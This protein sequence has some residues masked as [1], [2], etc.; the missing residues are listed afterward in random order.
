MDWNQAKQQTK[1]I[2]AGNG[3]QLQ[4]LQ[5]VVSGSDRYSTGSTTTY[6]YGDLTV[7]WITG[8]FKGIVSPIKEDDI[9]IEVG[10]Y[11]DDYL[12]VFIDPDQ[13][14]EYW[15]QL[16]IPSGS[17]NRYIILPIESWSPAGITVAKML[18]VRRLMPKSGSV[19]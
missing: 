1:A 11:E 17:D 12:K 13:S 7:F 2:I 10:F 8:S 6:G 4:Y 18:K 19:D 16:L 3:Q 15:D 9:R 14:C 5:R